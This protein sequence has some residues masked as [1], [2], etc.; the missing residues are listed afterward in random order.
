MGKKT[1]RTYKLLS[2]IIIS[3]CRIHHINI[4]LT[5]VFLNLSSLMFS[6]EY[7]KKSNYQHILSSFWCI[8]II[9]NRCLIVVSLVFILSLV[10]RI[11]Y[12]LKFTFNQLYSSIISD[13]NC[14]NKKEKYIY[15]V[16][17]FY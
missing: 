9:T 10:D 16:F 2:F 13:Y 1:R 12:K 11:S 3:S 8:I 4:H 15:I 17:L 7:N 6:Y 5:L 14:S